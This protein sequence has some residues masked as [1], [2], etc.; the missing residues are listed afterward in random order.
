MNKPIHIEEVALAVIAI[1]VMVIIIYGYD[2]LERK[3][4]KKC[5][6]KKIKQHREN[7]SQ[8]HKAQI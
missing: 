4:V 5:R 7:I 1:I 2:Y 8:K 6:M 3:I